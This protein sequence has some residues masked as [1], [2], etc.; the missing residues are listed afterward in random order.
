MREA[1]RI[2][3][4]YSPFSLNISTKIG[5]H[6]ADKGSGVENISV[7]VLSKARLFRLFSL[8]QKDFSFYLI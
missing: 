8:T 6:A 4:L 7:F 1:K 5:D 3:E 2:D